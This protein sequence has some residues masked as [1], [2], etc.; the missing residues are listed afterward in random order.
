MSMLTEIIAHS[1]DKQ[2]ALDALPAIACVRLSE[3]H[4]QVL[5]AAVLHEQRQ[6]IA[7]LSAIRP[8][9]VRL[10]SLLSSLDC[11]N[12][13]HQLRAELGLDNMDEV[14]R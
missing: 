13:E 14:P 2:P 9:L 4:W 3:A 5:T 10:A 12:A 8:D 6:V 1:R 11:L 7:E